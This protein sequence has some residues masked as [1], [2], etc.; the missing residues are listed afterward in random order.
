MS[1]CTCS[2]TR[3]CVPIRWSP[4]GRCSSSSTS[5]PASNPI[6]R[7][8]TTLSGTPRAES[9]N[10]I[11]THQSRLKNAVKHVV[12]YSVGRRMAERVRNWNL[13]AM[14]LPESVERSLAP[15]FLEDTSRDELTELIGRDLS[16]WNVF[17]DA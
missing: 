15:S 1:V 7:S 6:R 5:T 3:T 16:G 2:S 9:L 4:S 11:L 8:C 17:L 12:P 10:R 14:E 13:E